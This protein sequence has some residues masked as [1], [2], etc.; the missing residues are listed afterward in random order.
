M[1]TKY[2][3]I[4]YAMDKFEGGRFSRADQSGD[5][6]DISISFEGDL[7]VKVPNF[8]GTPRVIITPVR[9]TNLDP[10]STP[11]S[12]GRLGFNVMTPVC[13]ARDVTP[14]GF[15]LAARNA[16][17]DFG[18]FSAFNWIA[19]EETPGVENAVP[20]LQKGLFPPRH[21]DPAFESFLGNRSFEDHVYYEMHNPPISLDNNVASVQLT[22]TNQSVTEHNVA[23]VGIIN[24]PVE[25]QQLDLAAHNVD[26]TAGGCAFYGAAFSYEN[27][28]ASG[29]AGSEL[30]I[31]TGAVEEEWFEPS[32]H[33]GDWQTWDVVFASPFSELPVVLL[34]PYKPIDIPVRLSP[35]VLG[36]VQ[37]LTTGGFRIA[38]RNSD[39]GRGL[40]GFFWIAI[41]K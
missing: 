27:S 37:A 2:T 39:I 9:N 38:A 34:T 14:Q 16:D 3:Q 20:A 4:R 29:A 11:G 35:A 23:A 19:I 28:I 18:G 12:G 1:G 6:L 8:V 40:A 17:P 15:R 25:V 13:V 7:P 5:W 36:M 21:F 32:G 41:G 24:N 26:I 33:P 22:A 31:D 30:Q 10:T